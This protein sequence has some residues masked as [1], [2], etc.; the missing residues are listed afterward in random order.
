MIGKCL[1][2]VN[3]DEWKFLTLKKKKKSKACVGMKLVF[4]IP[5]TQVLQIVAFE[6]DI[7]DVHIGPI[8]GS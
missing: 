3:W 4:Y 8:A 7:D 6:L 5:N 2:L 1:N